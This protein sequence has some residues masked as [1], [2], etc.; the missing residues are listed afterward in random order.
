MVS[1]GKGFRLLAGEDGKAKKRAWSM[2][3]IAKG[4]Q[5]RGKTGV[6]AALGDGSDSRYSRLRS[7]GSPL[8]SVFEPHNQAAVPRS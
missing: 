6:D 4:E 7:K 8:N 2:K 5:R 1:T 3:G